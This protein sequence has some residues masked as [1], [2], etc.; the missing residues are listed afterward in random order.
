MQRVDRKSAEPKRIVLVIGG[1]EGGGAERI[2][3]D[4]A[5]YWAG[6]AWQVTLATWSG[7]DLADFYTLPPS[8]DRKWI[9]VRSGDSF[10]ARIRANFER[11]LEL[12]RLLVASKPDVV[13]SFI[14]VS[15]VLTIIAAAGLPARVVVSE[16]T[17]PGVYFSVE[18]QWRALRR[19]CY[20]WADKVVV[21]TKDA[22]KWVEENCRVK[23]IVIPNPL[24]ILPDI[25]CERE[26][27]VIAVG[28]LSKEKGF[29]IVLEAFARISPDFPGWHLAILGEGPERQA[30][31]DLRDRLGL[32][33]RAELLGQSREVEKWMARSGLVVHA[34][35]RE[36]FPNVVLEAMGM[37]AAVICADCHSG[38]A[39]LI[40]DGINGRLVPV[41]DVGAL[42]RAMSDLMS[43]PD[44]RRTLGQEASQVRQH[45]EQ[46]TIMRRW[47]A[48][49]RA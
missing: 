32:G 44:L 38:P 21:Q 39:E 28:R 34:S 12:R 14:T 43:K 7:P 13:L 35:R 5:A 16:R 31:L 11:V 26:L 48:C 2:L 25:A 29:D 18:P 47:E 27:L 4:M 6:K 46:A 41:G 9:D 1:L 33:G 19:L 24:R 22:A 20:R 36:G 8:V 15:N 17:S 45:Y 30:L 40:K 23:P 37:G 3:S 49:L 42:A 10:L